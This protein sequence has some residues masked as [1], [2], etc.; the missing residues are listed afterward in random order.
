MGEVGSCRLLTRS[1]S[2]Y[3]YTYNQLHLRQDDFFARKASEEESNRVQRS[4]PLCARLPK[5][6][7][8][9]GENVAFSEVNYLSLV[10]TTSAFKCVIAQ[11]RNSDQP[12]QVTHVTAVSIGHFK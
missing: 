9:L 12:T 2:M 1:S 11:V 7:N 8:G 3:S 5:L 6:E 10:L 4:R